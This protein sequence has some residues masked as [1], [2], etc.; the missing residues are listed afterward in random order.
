MEFTE[1]WVLLLILSR[2]FKRGVHTL[3]SKLSLFYNRF[4][5]V[6]SRCREPSQVVL[7]SEAHLSLRRVVIL[8]GK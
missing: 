4:Q 6:S 3:L 1:R 8:E 5:L 7:P 2:S